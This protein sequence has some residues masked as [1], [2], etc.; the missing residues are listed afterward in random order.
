MLYLSWSILVAMA[1]CWGLSVIG[2]P[3]IRRRH[4]RPTHPVRPENLD[5]LPI[6]STFE[7]LNAATRVHNSRRICAKRRQRLIGPA[8]RMIE[9]SGVCLGAMRWVDKN[10]A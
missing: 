5:K 9:T 8:N 6:R 10:I 7:F 3:A 2:P 1:L 4:W